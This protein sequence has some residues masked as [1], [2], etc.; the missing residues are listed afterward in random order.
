MQ[1][2]YQGKTYSMDLDDKLSVAEAR[3]LKQHT[4]FTIQDW[5]DGI[6]AADVDALCGIVFLAVRRAGDDIEWSDMDDM[7][8]MQLASDV[9]EVNGLD[10]DALKRGEQPALPAQMNRAQRRSNTAPKK[11]ASRAS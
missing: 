7:D 5:M 10:V 4:G 6:Q 11:T 3:A 2:K 9:A 1:F 8:L